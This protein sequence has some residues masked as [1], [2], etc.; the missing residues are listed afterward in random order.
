[1][2]ITQS[3]QANLQQKRMSEGMLGWGHN[4]IYSDL[5]AAQT[6]TSKSISV[7]L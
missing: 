1:M 2:T 7:L 4:W 5:I 6:S 3:T